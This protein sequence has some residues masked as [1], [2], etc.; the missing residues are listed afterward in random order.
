LNEYNDNF[1]IQYLSCVLIDLI[2]DTKVKIIMCDKGVLKLKLSMNQHQKD[3]HIQRQGCLFIKKLI[4]KSG[5]S[6]NV[7]TLNGDKVVI[8]AINNFNNRFDVIVEGCKCLRIMLN[9]NIN[10]SQIGKVYF[11]NAIKIIKNNMDVENQ[12]DTIDYLEKLT[13]SSECLNMMVEMDIFH[14]IITIIAY[15][16]R[17]Q[18]YLNKLKGLFMRVREIPIQHK[19]KLLI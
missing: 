8:N 11:E 10:V 18:D 15:N 6:N 16:N 13:H 19:K 1:N 3:Y 9:E 5:L 12:L 4:I 17:V 14:F 2:H 7:A